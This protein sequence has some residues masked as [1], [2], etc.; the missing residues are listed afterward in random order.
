MY[1]TKFF[2]LTAS[3]SL[4]QHSKLGRTHNT[5]TIASIWMVVLVSNNYSLRLFLKL[6]LRE[7]SIKVQSCPGIL[8][9]DIYTHNV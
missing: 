4:P 7:S 3:F 6:T 9:R 8:V 2:L 5:M 1:E